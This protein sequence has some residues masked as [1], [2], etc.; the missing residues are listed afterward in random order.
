MS[1]LISRYDTNYTLTFTKKSSFLSNCCWNSKDAR[2]AVVYSF[3]TRM[4]QVVN[5]AVTTEITM[6]CLLVGT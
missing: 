6:H 4:Q 2:M 3:T 5:A 1:K